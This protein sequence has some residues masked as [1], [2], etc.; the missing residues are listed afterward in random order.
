[1]EIK[2]AK[3]DCA[4]ALSYIHNNCFNEKWSENEFKTL[5]E[6]EKLWKFFV[7]EN[8]KE[9]IGYISSY[10]IV[11]EANIVNIAV[12]EKYRKMGYGSLILEK[13]ISFCKENGILKIMLEV[14]KS[15]IGAIALYEKYGFYKVGESKN[16]YKNPT[17]DAFLMNKML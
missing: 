17:E 12:L 3:A 10:L 2:S 7:A 9:P 8:E 5:M 16:H 13:F 11:D 14:R 6:N 1:M 15:N 4:D